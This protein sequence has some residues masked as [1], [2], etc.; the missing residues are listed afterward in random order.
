[1][2]SKRLARQWL[3]DLLA[4]KAPYEPGVINVMVLYQDQI[5][6]DHDGEIQ[7]IA[8]LDERALANV[9]GYLASQAAALERRTARACVEEL[10][11]S[12]DEQMDPVDVGQLVVIALDA[13][14]PRDPMEWLMATPLIQAIATRIAWLRLDG[15]LPT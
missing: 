3:C 13:L 8:E 1:M 7:R 12:V 15:D 14:Q 9:I 2:A 11:M 5:W 6:V 10:L 4:G